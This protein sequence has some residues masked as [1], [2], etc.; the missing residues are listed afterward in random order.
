MRE[1]WRP[2][3]ADG[4]KGDFGRVVV[5]GGSEVYSGAPAL[6]ALAAIRGGADLV[7]VVAPR[8]AADIV[9]GFAPDLITVPCST[10]YP[11]PEQVLALADQA[12]ALVLGGGVARNATTHG[13]LAR[14]LRGWKKP[15]VADAEALHALAA[16]PSTFEPKRALL[17]PHPGEFAVVAGEPW[18][19]GDDAR[20]AAARKLAAKYGSAVLVKSHRDVV[21]DPDRARVDSSGSP[22]MTKGGWGDLLAGAAGA[23]LARGLDAYDAAAGAAWLVGEAGA[24]AAATRGEATL[25]SDALAHFGDLL[26]GAG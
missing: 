5:A 23:L 18:P 12:D 3:P 1:L 17:T 22:F 21:A 15:L 24:R 9:A 2:R 25:A 8:R 11:D 10:P 7:H 4:R 16:H 20:A 19:F 6:N 26:T 14:I 13:A